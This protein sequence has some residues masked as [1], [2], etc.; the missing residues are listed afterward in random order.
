MVY[1]SIFQHTYHM[2]SG[3]VSSPLG[4][5]LLSDEGNILI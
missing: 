5:L 2:H 1:F 3:D 4:P